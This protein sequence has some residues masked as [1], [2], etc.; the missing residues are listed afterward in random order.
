[1]M[2]GFVTLEGDFVWGH[3]KNM[4]V[5]ILGSNHTNGQTISIMA[6][7]DGEGQSRVTISNNFLLPQQLKIVNLLFP[8]YQM[9]L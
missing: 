3:V 4:G 6:N 5:E 7:A 9:D 8:A 1:M 2:Q